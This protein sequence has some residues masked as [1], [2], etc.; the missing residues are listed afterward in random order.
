MLKRSHD[1]RVEAM[2]CEERR[3]QELISRLRVQ[4]EEA[5]KSEEEARTRT[6]R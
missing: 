1:E 3:Q 5:R 4:L 2:R 6:R